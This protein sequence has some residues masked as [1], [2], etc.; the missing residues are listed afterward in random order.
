M[1]QRMHPNA[2]KRVLYYTNCLNRSVILHD[3]IDRKTLSV[4]LRSWKLVL[5][6]NNYLIDRLQDGCNMYSSRIDRTK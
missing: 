3:G 5:I 2:V 6:I 4:F 1:L